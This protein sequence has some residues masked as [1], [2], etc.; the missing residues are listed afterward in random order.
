[1]KKSK[2]TKINLVDYIYIL[3][4]YICN[5]TKGVQT[6]RSIP[7]VSRMSAKKVNFSFFKR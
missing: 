1:M 5:N 2:L 3:N 4:W 6:R 7:N